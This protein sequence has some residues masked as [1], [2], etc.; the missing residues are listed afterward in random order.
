MQ[1]R[2]CAESV[3]I[4]RPQLAGLRELSELMGGLNSAGTQT[5][6]CRMAIQ[7]RELERSGCVRLHQVWNILTTEAQKTA[8]VA[9]G[10]IE[11]YNVHAY[12][13][14]WIV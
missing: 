4:T 12:I 10:N 13:P 11:G 3:N 7:W 14:T 5:L 6:V 1:F 9:Y 2:C 8:I